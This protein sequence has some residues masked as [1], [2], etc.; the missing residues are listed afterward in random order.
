MSCAISFSR[1]RNIS[2]DGSFVRMCVSLCRISGW[3]TTVSVSDMVA[4][5]FSLELKSENSAV[6][7]DGHRGSATFAPL[8]RNTPACGPGAAFQHTGERKRLRGDAE[9]LADGY[10]D[11]IEADHR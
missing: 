2:V 4:S 7:H 5:I 9:D 11:P 6:A 3:P 8:C 10:S 1:R